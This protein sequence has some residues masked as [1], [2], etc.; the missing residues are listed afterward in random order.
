MGRRIARRTTCIIRI[1]LHKNYSLRKK[2]RK[3]LFKKKK[4]KI[5]IKQLTT[6]ALVCITSLVNGQDIKLKIVNQYG[7]KLE[8]LK[9]II[10]GQTTE[11]ST[12]KDGT[13]L[14]PVPT[15][16]SFTLAAKHCENKTFA[17]S[18][19]QQDGNIEM[20]KH[21][22]WKDLL[23]PMFYIKYGGLWMLLFIVFAETGLFA[24]FFLPGDSLLFVAG[25]FSGPLAN[26]FLKLIGLSN[27]G[28][29]IQLL[30]LIALIS[31]AGIIGNF[32][33]YWFGRR[34]G[35]AMYTWPDKFL[36]KKRYLHQAQEF[37]EKNGAGTIVVA[38]FM[39]IVRTFAPIVAGIVNMNKAKFTFYNILGCVAWVT[40]MLLLGH[41][42]DKA[43]PSLKN[44]LELIVLAIVFVTTAPVLYKLIARKKS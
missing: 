3:K 15:A 29:L 12:E 27:A 22:S 37:Y 40:S 20:S 30:V 36:F 14:L 33:G 5:V 17:A 7:A 16:D 4:A 8:G 34:V 10:N 44:H 2:E 6:I 23:S 35:P 19:I 11:L 9:I 32:V 39:P 31:G 1:V 43:Y 28:E 24:G 38:R 26:E 13:I 21:F 42:L 25:I 18:I 41:F